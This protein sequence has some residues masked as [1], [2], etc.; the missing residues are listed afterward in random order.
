MHFR[1]A[2]VLR[3]TAVYTRFLWKSSQAPHTFINQ[4]CGYCRI[5]QL[6]SSVTLANTSP[7][8]FITSFL[9]PKNE[10]KKKKTFS[11]PS[12]GQFHSSLLTSSIMI[13]IKTQTETK[14]ETE[15]M[16]KKMISHM[17]YILLHPCC[18]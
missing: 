6:A 12:S 9:H 15:T 11:K 3:A 18:Y 8:L 7:T 13:C 17:L 10:K 1:F 4:P 5:S 16:M 14:R 2:S